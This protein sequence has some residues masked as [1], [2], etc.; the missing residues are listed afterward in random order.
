MA[1]MNKWMNKFNKYSFCDAPPRNIVK[2]FSNSLKYTGHNYFK[3]S[4]EDNCT[5]YELRL[6]YYLDPNSV[7]VLVNNEY[8]FKAQSVKEW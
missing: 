1:L 2:I 3:R 6:C 8:T 7:E 5:G 4:P